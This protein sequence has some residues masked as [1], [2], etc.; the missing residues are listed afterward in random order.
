[1]DHQNNIESKSHLTPLPVKSFVVAPGDV[2]GGFIYIMDK[3]V[4]IEEG[5]IGISIDNPS[6]QD[7]IKEQLNLLEAGTNTNKALQAKYNQIK[8]SEKYQN[9]TSEKEKI[10]FLIHHKEHVKHRYPVTLSD[11]NKT[12]FKLGKLHE[13][14]AFRAYYENVG[15]GGLLFSAYKNQIGVDDTKHFAAQINQF[16]NA[17]KND[18]SKEN[19]KEQDVF[20]VKQ[21][22]KLVYGR[23][24]PGVRRIL[25]TE[26]GQKFQIL[27]NPFIVGATGGLSLLAF[28]GATYAWRGA[29]LSRGTISTVN[30][31][32]IVE[33][34][35]TKIANIRGFESQDIEKI[36]G[37]YGKGG[38][39]KIGTV[40]KWS[41]GCKDGTGRLAGGEKNKTN[42]MVCCDENN[43]HIK[44]DKNNKMIR[45]IADPK[46]KDKM[47]YI[48]EGKKVPKSV[49][50]KAMAVSE[51]RVAGLGESLASFICMG[52]R[53]GI[54]E[55]GQNKVFKKIDPP[56]G[57]FT[58]Q[59]FGIDFGKAYEKA[60][61][62]VDPKIGNLQDDFSFNNPENRK[63]RFLN[64]SMLYDNPLRD[65]MKGI[66]LMAALRN[67]LSDE[68]KKI[69]VAEYR[70]S[71]DTE[72]ADKLESYPKS[73]E[74][75]YKAELTGARTWLEN[76]DLFLIKKEENDYRLKA[77]NQ[78][79]SPQEKKHYLAYA[80][81]LANVYKAAKETDDKV[82]NIFTKRLA[83]T[84]S[85]ID[86]IDN[87]EK[88]TAKKV[89]ILS[90]D[91]KVILNHIRVENKNRTPWQLEPSADGQSFVL[92]C[93]SKGSDI[94]SKLKK[95]P[96]IEKEIDLNNMKKDN[97][98]ITI[99]L[100][101]AQLENI[102][103]ALTEEK[104]AKVRGLN[105]Y[106]TEAIKEA[107][108]RDL[109]NKVQNISI[110]VKV[111]KKVKV[112]NVAEP[113]PKKVSFKKE[114]ALPQP[115]KGFLAGYKSA[116]TAYKTQ[117]IT[118]EE[119]KQHYKSKINN[120]KG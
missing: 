110:A 47:I 109:N 118:K 15:M 2:V 69:I 32:A 16:M 26:I 61:P 113:I 52:D 72:F 88:L 79:I 53:D 39:P 106:R 87:L 12:F 74:E 8:N 35:A 30:S 119:K 50:D 108:D 99:T 54:G 85:Q 42:V 19:P 5:M 57:K 86:V 107:F 33:T 56:K 10:D 68:Q 102:S 92:S 64:A 105:Q 101:K 77:Q 24:G 43:N 65:K 67:K 75:K 55:V 4:G 93:D 6:Y 48:R 71:G 115:K 37:D 38:P 120:R 18:L 28:A 7:F 3:P 59:F 78:N 82:L 44:V 46:N 95:I 20:M 41:A 27:A 100:S 34:A 36:T 17:D 91:G 117:K 45:P 13:V 66:Y 97:N 114:E 40:V 62:I 89:H 90:S 80:D 58:L 103:K 49:Y 22:G 21:D 63:E 98:K 14:K 60:N 84:P 73:L 81:R 23:T 76:G 1:M 11:I 9:L 111:H 83:L 104:V 25:K 116:M 112:E 70:V 94:L 51:Y 31:D 96:E 29:L